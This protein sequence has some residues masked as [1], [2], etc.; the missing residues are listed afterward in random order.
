MWKPSRPGSTCARLISGGAEGFTIRRN[1]QDGRTS[2]LPALPAAIAG[3]VS[4]PMADCRPKF[5][6]RSQGAQDGVAVHGTEARRRWWRARLPQLDASASK[7]S[8]GSGA[9]ANRA[10]PGRV[11]CPLF[12]CST[13]CITMATYG[14][15]MRSGW[16]MNQWDVE[17]RSDR[18]CGWVV[19]RGQCGVWSVSWVVSDGK[20]EIP[21]APRR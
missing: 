13:G 20:L 16:T 11:E 14:K 8:S 21:T 19:G 9:L 18:I 5:C 10:L 1:T 3:R 17:K 6:T 12:P 4:E 15:K 2:R 7:E